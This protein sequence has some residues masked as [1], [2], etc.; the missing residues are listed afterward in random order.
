MDFEQYAVSEEKPKEE[1]AAK[2]VDTG[3]PAV[4]VAA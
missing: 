1:I 4:A 2:L 3:A